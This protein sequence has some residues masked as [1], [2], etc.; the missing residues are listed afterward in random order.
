MQAVWPEMEVSKVPPKIGEGMTEYLQFL[1]TRRIRFRAA[2][3]VS[4]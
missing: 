4:K 1:E 2:A 3:G